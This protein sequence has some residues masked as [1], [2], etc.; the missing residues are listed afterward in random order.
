MSVV[1]HQPHCVSMERFFSL[2][3]LAY[4][5]FLVPTALA[6]I[7]LST[8]NFAA[9]FASGSGVLKSLRPS[10]ES[11]FD[12]SPSDVFHLRNDNG[13]YHTGDLTIQFHNVGDSQWTTADTSQLRQNIT[14]T[15]TK[16]G[17]T[18]VSD[19]NGA[20]HNST[21]TLNVTRT[22]QDNDGDLALSFTI[23]NIAS[24]AIELGSLGFPIEFNNIITNRTATE[25]TNKCVFV[26]PYLGLNAGYAQV[27]RFTG[28]GP[29]LVVTP[30]THDSKFEAWQFLNEP[31]GN[32]LVGYQIQTYE[33]NYA[34]Q[35]LSK[36]LA[37]TEW[38]DAE[39]WNPPTSTILQPEDSMTVGLRFSVANQ[40]QNIES[41][42]AQQQP[43]AVGF[44]GYVLPNDL[45]ANLFLDSKQGVKSITAYPTGSLQVARCSS[46]GQS[47]KGY[48]V[49]AGQGAFGRARLVIEYADDT[50]QAVHYWIAH[51]SPT[52]L[53]QFGNFLTTDQWFVNDSD[54]FGRSPSV[55]TYDR[56]K[57]DYVDQENRTWIAGIS[58][59][60]GAGSFLA[61]GMK[62]SVWP[63]PAEVAKLESMAHESVFGH[64]QADSGNE[65]YSVKRSLF[66]YEPKLVPDYVYDPYFNWSSVPFPSQ[67]KE[68]AYATDRTYNY[69]HVSALYWGIYRAGRTHPD[70]LTKAVP[71][72]YLLQAYHTIAYSVSNSTSGIPHTGYWNVGLMVGKLL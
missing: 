20:L 10:L 72:W 17:N 14:T 1:S 56:A 69:V 13:Q 48:N 63:D 43:V 18:V 33:G 54:P 38:Q 37:E 52:A 22:W 66:Y 25:A 65:T 46:H 57:N 32:E 71:S 8:K 50:L 60:G 42:V 55:I 64:L 6:E 7:Q 40:V 16:T 36:G 31:Y 58:D 23:E 62:Q 27:T 15:S 30:L 28:K 70:I 3:S 12:F 34:W 49:N 41:V 35:V 59:E 68:A 53:S 61:A 2:R 11:S 4:L 29:N 44:P 5:L 21:S 9:S 19:L 47:W 39:P 24:T 26:D 45:T 51:S 67:D